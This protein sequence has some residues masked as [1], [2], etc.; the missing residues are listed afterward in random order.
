M[1]Y[2]LTYVSGFAASQLLLV[3]ILKVRIFTGMSTM[4]PS[5]RDKTSFL[6]FLG[7]L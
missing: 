2:R 4:P 3:N 1:N 5:S 6:E 7:A